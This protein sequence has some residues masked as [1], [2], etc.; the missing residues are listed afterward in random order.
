MESKQ[1][2]NRQQRTEKLEDTN[3]L[4]IHL[5]DELYELIMY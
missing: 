4:L 5:N 3:K 1:I 2:K